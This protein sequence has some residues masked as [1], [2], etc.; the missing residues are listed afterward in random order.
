MNT[1]GCPICGGSTKLR[2]E[3]PLRSG[4]FGNL[5]S[6]TH[7][8]LQCST[9]GVGFVE[10][11]PDIDYGLQDYRQ[12]YNVSAEI[13][14]YF[15]RHD[16]LQLE[17]LFQMRNLPLRGSVV[18]DFGCG[19][20]ALL[21][22]LKGAAKATVAVEPFT[23]FHDALRGAGHQVFGNPEALLEGTAPAIGLALS[24]H[25]I[26]H[27][28]DPVAYLNT[29]R[30][31]LSPRGRIVVATPNL[32]ELLMTLSV[33]EYDRFYFRTAHR[34]YFT[35]DSLRITAEAAGLSVSENRCV[36]T[37]DVS[38]VICWLRDRV[39][40]GNGR[41]NMFD[42]RLDADWKAFVE[43]AGMADTLWMELTPREA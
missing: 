27:V 17:Y 42:G 8:V 11:P 29:I 38:N 35:R 14:D 9:C 21:D 15:R 1:K 3:G 32:D 22:F 26:E 40:T 10:N 2:Y 39:P 41:L 25:V 23:G 12:A 16:S 43:R 7:I 5:T 24:M 34:W 36:A 30:Q 18:A 19:G 37:Y 4:S 6:D 13:S 28:D 20:G 33:P 31:S